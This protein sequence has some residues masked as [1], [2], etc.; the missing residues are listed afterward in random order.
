MNVIAPWYYP[1]EENATVWVYSYGSSG[2][3]LGTKDLVTVTFSGASD[4]SIQI[5][6]P[7]A[8][9][10]NDTEGVC[11]NSNGNPNDDPTCPD[12]EPINTCWQRDHGSTSAMP[13]TPLHT[14]ATGT[15]VA[16]TSS[17]P[18]CDQTAVD[19]ECSIITD[20]NGPFEVCVLYAG[21][22]AS[23]Y[24]QS[25][26]FDM[27]LAGNQTNEICALLQSYADA[28]MQAVP[29]ATLQW[30]SEDFCR[31]SSFVYYHRLS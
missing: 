18:T 14:Q 30:R 5:Q 31:K 23:E 20:P 13:S 24:Y 6:A 15:V 27:C 3:L 29:S 11:G 12:G 9:Y 19:Q 10:E 22:L 4:Y 26:T 8:I 25:C 1:N 16:T 21:N 2:H 28:C 7:L 17:G